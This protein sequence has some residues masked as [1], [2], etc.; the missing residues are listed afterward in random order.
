M[1]SVADRSEPLIQGEKGGCFEWLVRQM[2]N[3]VKCFAISTFVLLVTIGIAI[4]LLFAFA[5]DT[6][7]PTMKGFEMIDIVNMYSCFSF[8]YLVFLVELQIR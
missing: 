6:Q 3:Q 1:S 7:S 4:G 2:A 5:K 8:S